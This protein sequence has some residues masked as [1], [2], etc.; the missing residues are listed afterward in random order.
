MLK[1]FVKPHVL[2]AALFAGC[3]GLIPLI[4]LAQESPLTMQLQESPSPG[5]LLDVHFQ[6]AKHGWVVGAGGTM[7]H[8]EDG[9]VT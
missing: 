2:V 9:G 8:T 6:D 5:T 4:G 7:L 3:L 1:D